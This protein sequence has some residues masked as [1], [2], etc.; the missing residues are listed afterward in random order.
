MCVWVRLPE[1]DFSASLHLP[2]LQ[3]P[4]IHRQKTQAPIWGLLSMLQ[5]SNSCGLHLGAAIPLCPFSAH[6][7]LEVHPLQL[8]NWSLEDR[9]VRGCPGSRGS[10]G[11]PAHLLA[12]SGLSICLW[13]FC[14]LGNKVGMG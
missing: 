7:V 1:Q 11:R 8:P 12:P 5:R 3:G 2:I 4:S 13:Q 6:L 9:W 10:K 14:Y